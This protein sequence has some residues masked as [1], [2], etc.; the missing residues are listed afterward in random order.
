MT[1]FIP[2]EFGIETRKYRD[3]KIGGLVGAKVKNTDYLIELAGKHDWFSWT[4]LSNGLF[5]D[6]VGHFIVMA[7]GHDSVLTTIADARAR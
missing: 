6:W 7:T 5:F 3:T 4:G 2:S 1:R